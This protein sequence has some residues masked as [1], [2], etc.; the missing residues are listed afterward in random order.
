MAP[1]TAITRVT[2]K[3]QT[4]FDVRTSK[5]IVEGVAVPLDSPELV[6]DGGAPYME[7]WAPGAFSRQMNDPAAIGRIRFNFSHADDGLM[8]WIGRTTRLEERDGALWGQWKV[9]DSPF[10]D[11]VLFKLGDGQLPGLSIAARVLDDER[12]GTVTR[13]LVGFLEH[14]ASVE[15]PAFSSALVSSVREKKT[16]APLLDKWRT[17]GFGPSC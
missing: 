12:R 13:R 16:P 10:G 2:R 3:F 15:F 17:R 14:V 9:D 7:E 4:D 5:R 6:S 11:A 8:T 1:A